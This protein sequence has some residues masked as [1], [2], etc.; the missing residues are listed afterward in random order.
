MERALVYKE[1]ILNVDNEKIIAELSE[2]RKE[3]KLWEEYSN[4]NDGEQI[5]PYHGNGEPKFANFKEAFCALD[6]L[7]SKVV[8]VFSNTYK[9]N[10][11]YLWYNINVPGS[12]NNAH[13][14]NEENF[15]SIMSG[16]YYISAPVDSGDLIFTESN[17]RYEPSSGSLI[18][19][20][21]TT[22]HAVDV[23]LS[24][25]NRISMAFNLYN[26]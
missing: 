21:P 5:H 17:E 26:D 3:K 24:D 6:E 1:T 11:I 22:W 13:H 20:D 14:H 19:F 8:E 2:L 18:Y 25:E 12:Y 7:Q 16:V 9:F 4:A 15:E 23:N 10:N